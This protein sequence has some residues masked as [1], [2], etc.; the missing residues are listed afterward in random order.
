MASVHGIEFSL[1]IDVVVESSPIHG[2]S[3]VFSSLNFLTSEKGDEDTGLEVQLEVH[4]S[5]EMLHS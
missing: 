2:N 5:D 3:N 4:F 1:S